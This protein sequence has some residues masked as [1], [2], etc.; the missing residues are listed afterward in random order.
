MPLS[1]W[2]DK[3][4][5]WNRPSPAPQASID[6]DII[7]AHLYHS[8]TSTRPTITR[9]ASSHQHQRHVRTIF[10][11]YPHSS[12]PGKKQKPKMSLSQITGELPT[13]NTPTAL[14]YSRARGQ[15]IQ[16]S[17]STQQAIFWFSQRVGTSVI[18]GSLRSILPSSSSQTMNNDSIM[19]MLFFHLSP[20]SWQSSPQYSKL[21]SP[22]EVTVRALRCP[23]FVSST[24]PGGAWRHAFHPAWPV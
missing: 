5:Q 23:F 17:I 13:Q 10:N 3:V 18:I 20:I 22:P 12:L 24:G 9:P 16:Q 7:T 19:T 1:S 21:F 2:G 4:H 6:S 11:I 8:S 15:H 14:W